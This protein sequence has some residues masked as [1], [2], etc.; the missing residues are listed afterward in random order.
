[1]VETPRNGRVVSRGRP[2]AKGNPGRPRGARH[3][4]TVLAET[5]AVQRRGD[6]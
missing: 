4:T 3:K 2:F 6:R 1:M 5:H